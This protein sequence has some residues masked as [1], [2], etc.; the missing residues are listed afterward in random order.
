MR[1]N[2]EKALLPRVR[3]IDPSAGTRGLDEF[4]AN[5]HEVQA[6]IPGAE[7][8]R[9]SGVDADRAFSL[10]SSTTA[11]YGRYGNSAQG[12]LAGQSGFPS[13]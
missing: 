11:E 2:L 8:L 3:F 1:G 12:P 7:Y 10:R 4:E 5:V 13:T 6:R 9:T